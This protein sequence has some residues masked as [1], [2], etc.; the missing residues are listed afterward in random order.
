MITTTRNLSNLPA[1]SIE[2]ISVS[3]ADAINNKSGVYQY[4]QDAT[5]EKFGKPKSTLITSRGRNAANDANAENTVYA[6]NTADFNVSTGLVPTFN[7]GFGGKNINKYVNIANAGRG[8]RGKSITFTAVDADGNQSLSALEGLEF[9]ILSYSATG[10][11]ELP[12]VLD[13]SEAIR[14]TQVQ[15]GVL[16]IAVDFWVNGVTQLSWVVPAGFTV[17]ANISWA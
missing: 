6:F 3:V 10:G 14:N 1:Q 13:L 5:I 17:T 16:T 11:R 15:Q 2:K 8:L 7:D 9:A 12:E 4:P